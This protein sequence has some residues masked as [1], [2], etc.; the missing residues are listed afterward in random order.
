MELENFLVQRKSIT[1][2]YI[3]IVDNLGSPS[4]VP[5]AFY[6][7]YFADKRLERYWKRFVELLYVSYPC[8]FD[9]E[10]IDRIR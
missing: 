4:V 1:D 6:F 7:N 9:E 8:I 3:R 5:L 2:Y 10:F